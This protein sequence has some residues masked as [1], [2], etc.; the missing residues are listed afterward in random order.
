MPDATAETFTRAL[1]EA[2]QKRDP[3]PIVALFADDAE[4]ENLTA[5]SPATGR[6]GA[7]QF[8][9]KYLDSFR[10][11][12]SNFTHTHQAGDTAVLEWVSEGELPDGQPIRYRGVS[13]VEFAGGR[14]VKFRTYYDSAAFVAAGA[15][16]K[17][18]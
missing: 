18:Q 5:K 14:V 3:G 16:G 13:V 12:A 1:Q 2:E 6:D 11:I 8:W 4:L 7:Q 15:T 17:S 10:R 9:A